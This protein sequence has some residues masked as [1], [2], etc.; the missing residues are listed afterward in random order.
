MLKLLQKIED[1]KSWFAES[2]NSVK[3]VKCRVPLHLVLHFI[4]ILKESQGVIYFM[5]KKWCVGDR[6]LGCNPKKW[7]VECC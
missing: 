5:L 2:Y 1:V 4:V 7:N 6:T 3:K